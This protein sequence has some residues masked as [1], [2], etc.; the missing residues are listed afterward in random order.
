[1]FTKPPKLNIHICYNKTGR[2][3]VETNNSIH[4]SWVSSDFLSCTRA[5]M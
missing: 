5:A 2:D 1:M 3:V 4:G